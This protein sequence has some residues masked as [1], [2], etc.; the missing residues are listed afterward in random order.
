VDDATI[1]VSIG[2]FGV[3]ND[4]GFPLPSIYGVGYTVDQFADGSVFI[5]GYVNSLSSTASDSIFYA[6][7]QTGWS[8]APISFIF[9]VYELADGGTW[10]ISL[11]RTSLVATIEYHDV[12]LVSPGVLS[13]SWLPS[14]CVINSY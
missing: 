3:I 6:P 10:D 13:W 1:T 4:S 8:T 5:T 12:D 14:Q 11:D 7:A 2:C 9:D